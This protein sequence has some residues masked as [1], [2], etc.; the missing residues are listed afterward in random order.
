[1]PTYSDNQSLN[2]T[3][4]G[5]G[6]DEGQGYIYFGYPKSYPLLK[7]IIDYNGLDVITDF[8]TYSVKISSPNNYWQS[9]DYIFYVNDDLTTVEYKP[10][11]WNFMFVTQSTP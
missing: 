4:K 11:P 9:R 3:T 10:I 5:L 8:K 7:A 6:V 2:I 1:M